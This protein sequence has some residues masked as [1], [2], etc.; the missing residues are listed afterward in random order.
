MRI[1]A[2]DTSQCL[3]LLKTFASLHVCRLV[4]D[5]I[6]FGMF[7]LVSVI[8]VVERQTRAVLE[9]G[10]AML[11]GVAVAIGAKIDLSFT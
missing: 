3:A 5:V 4:G 1:V 6:L 10:S 8:K 11:Q 9:C 2:G 7:C